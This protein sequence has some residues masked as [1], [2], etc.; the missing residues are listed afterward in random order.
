M[1]YIKKNIEELSRSRPYLQL[2][3]AAK[4]GQPEIVAYYATGERKAV[5]IPRWKQGQIQ[6]LV[7]ELC[8]SSSPLNEGRHFPRPVKS[9]AGS[10]GDKTILQWN[11]FNVFSLILP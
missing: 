8:D 5:Q 4:S 3:I 2:V 10:R 7:D 6:T 9:G 11:P 1:K